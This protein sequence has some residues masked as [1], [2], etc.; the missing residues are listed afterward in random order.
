MFMAEQFFDGRFSYLAP[1]AGRG[2]IALAI[3][4]RGR[5]RTTE[6]AG[7]CGKSPSPQPSPRKSGEREFS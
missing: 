3:R 1:L 7:I 2:R 4:V 5:R 6:F